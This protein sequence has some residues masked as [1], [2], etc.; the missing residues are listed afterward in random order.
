MTRDGQP[1]QWKV[2]AGYMEVVPGTGTI[3]TIEEFGDCQLHIEWASPIK[4]TGDGQKRG[5]SGVFLMGRYEIQVLDS[6]QNPTY[7]DGY[8]GSIY[9]EFPPL[10]N[11]SRK[12]GEWQSF[13][14]LWT[15][16]RFDGEKLVSPAYVTIIHNG[17]VIHNHTALTGPTTHRKIKEYEAHP[18]QGPIL[19]QDHNDLVR[20][21][22][23]WCRPINGYD[24]N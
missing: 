21:R 17:V 16:P 24:G 19:L 1:A 23:I 11:A 3:K 18:P 6:Y 4:V 14:I 10:V 7:A 2:E 20:F 5:N 15:A 12:P 8:A 13:D 22:N 9:G